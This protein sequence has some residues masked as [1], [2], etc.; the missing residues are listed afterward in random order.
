MRVEPYNWE[1]KILPTNIQF[2]IKLL[3]MTER[4]II[5][6][7]VS[8]VWPV[9]ARG[10]IAE[11]KVAKLQTRLKLSAITPV[12]TRNAK[13]RPL[14]QPEFDQL[15]IYLGYVHS[16][17]ESLIVL[18]TPIWLDSDIF[19]DKTYRIE[20]VTGSRN[21]PSYL[22]IETRIFVLLEHVPLAL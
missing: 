6:S 4:V 19:T 11:S 3:A 1:A 5:F 20:A 9:T 22:M 13:P 16:Q 14:S 17:S 8:R 7:H 12:N 2:W 15:K 10:K 21:R 18:S